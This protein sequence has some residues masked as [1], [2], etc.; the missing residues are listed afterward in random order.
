MPPRV[1]RS[2]LD[3]I[4]NGGPTDC[5]SCYPSTR[6]IRRLIEELKEYDVDARSLDMLSPAA[7]WN[8]ILDGKGTEAAASD[9][10]PVLLVSTLANTETL[11]FQTF[12]TPSS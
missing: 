7:G 1:P 4:R 5:A 12:P 11:T 9:K 6:P 10:D 3:L 2:H 8:H